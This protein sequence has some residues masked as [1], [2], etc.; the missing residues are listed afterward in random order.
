LRLSVNK[1]SAVN[2]LGLFL[3]SYR[4]LMQYHGPKRKTKRQD[5]EAPMPTEIDINFLKVRPNC[6]VWRLLTSLALRLLNFYNSGYSLSKA[7]DLRCVESLVILYFS[8]MSVKD[9]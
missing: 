5:H 9:S 3:P 1:D 8:A 4:A 7:A 6:S 2:F